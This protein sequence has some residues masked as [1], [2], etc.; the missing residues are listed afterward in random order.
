MTDFLKHRNDFNTDAFA[1]V[2]DELTFWSARFGLLLFNHLEIRKGIE[3][4]DLGCATGFPL[5]ELA[6]VHGASCHVTGLD[7]WPQAIERARAKLAYHKLPNVRVVEADGAHQPFADGEFDLIVSNLGIN[8]FDAPHVVLA[9]CFRVAKPAARIVFT[10]N[11]KGHMR[12]FYD[13]F[14]DVLT[15]MNQS[16]YLARL[17]A[18]EDRRGT[19]ESVCDLVRQ[20]GFS[21]E[22][23]IEDGFHLRYLDGTAFFNHSL[24]KIGFLDGW[25]SVV[26][27]DDEEKVFAALERKLNE[28]ADKN[29]ELRMTVPMLYVE[30]VKK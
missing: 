18:N 12:E 20:A 25:R 10:T 23:T 22:K 7:I 2:F 3:I 14:R 4:L 17:S 13:V 6:N 21:V 26:D 28:L 8:N 27:A 1:A 24:T 16:E 9:E 29:G 19:K 30:G 15:G 11:P 5:F